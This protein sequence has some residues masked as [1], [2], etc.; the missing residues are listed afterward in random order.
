MMDKL[1][2]VINYVMYPYA[3]PIFFSCAY[4]FALSTSLMHETYIHYVVNHILSKRT[5]FLHLVIITCACIT[6]IY[7]VEF[8][9]IGGCVYF[10]HIDVFHGAAGICIPCNFDV[11]LSPS[12]DT[13]AKLEYSNACT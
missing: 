4:I 3:C 9:I 2:N 8:A 5:D 11:C 1:D 7:I 10:Q 12:L 6:H 13:S